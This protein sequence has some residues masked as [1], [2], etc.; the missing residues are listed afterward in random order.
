MVEEIAPAPG[1][2]SVKRSTSTTYDEVKAL[3]DKNPGVQYSVFVKTLLVSKAF[4]NALERL[5]MDTFDTLVRTTN[6][7]TQQ[8]AMVQY[9]TGTLIFN[10]LGEKIAKMT[11]AV[12]REV[13]DFLAVAL[14]IARLYRSGYAQ[15]KRVPTCLVDGF[16]KQIPRHSSQRFGVVERMLTQAILGELGYDGEMPLWQDAEDGTAASAKED[17][18]ASLSGKADLT[19][20][21]EKDADLREGQRESGRSDATKRRGIEHRSD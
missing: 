3:L 19:S 4:I 5:N 1:A 17:D 11:P 15:H 20:L 18:E 14:L 21:P 16:T 8:I 12:N 13:G 7:V 2:A 6:A 9:E 10:E